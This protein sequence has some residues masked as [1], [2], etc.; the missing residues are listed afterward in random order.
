MSLLLPALLKLRSMMNE[1]ERGLPKQFSD[2]VHR[3]SCQTK[4]LDSFTQCILYTHSLHVA[5]QMH[6]THTHTLTR[7][8]F[9]NE[10]G[11]PYRMGNV[12]LLL[13]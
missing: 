6:T 7:L 3:P 2:I 12:L 11:T 1:L 8:L 10:S 13:A 4:A 9:M 5:L